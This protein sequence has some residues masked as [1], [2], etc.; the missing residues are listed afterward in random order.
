MGAYLTL[1]AWPRMCLTM[2]MIPPA[3]AAIVEIE[4]R[5]D[6]VLRKLEELETEIERVLADFNAEREFFKP[7]ARAA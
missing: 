1:L 4:A 5:Q 3:I 7:A 6:E 2:P